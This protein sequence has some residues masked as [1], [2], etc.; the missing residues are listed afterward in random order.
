M[1]VSKVGVQ[2]TQNEQGPKAG[3]E[4]RGKYIWGFFKCPAFKY[5]FLSSSLK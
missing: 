5:F 1:F 4:K 3:G 2:P